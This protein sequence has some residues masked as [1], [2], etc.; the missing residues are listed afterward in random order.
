MANSKTTLPCD[1]PASAAAPTCLK[2][3]RVWRLGNADRVLKSLGSSCRLGLRDR[4]KHRRVV[5]CDTAAGILVSLLLFRFR[6]VRDFKALAT[7]A[8]KH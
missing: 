6:E 4:S 8:G 1:R 2:I 7:E 5:I 3:P